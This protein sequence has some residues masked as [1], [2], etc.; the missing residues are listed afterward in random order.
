VRRF[1]LKT[2]KGLL[3]LVLA[4]MI[5]IAAWHE[6]AR[7]V[8]PRLLI[9]VLAAG[10]FDMVVLRLRHTRWQFP[11]GAVL[12]AMIAGMVLSVQTPW[13]VIPAASLAG[14]A[15]KYAFRTRGANVFNPAALGIVA[16]VPAFHP[17]QNWWGAL[18]DVSPL[19][20]LALPA[21]GIFIARRVNKLALV[22]AFLGFYFALFTAAAF[23]RDPA[24]VSEIFRAPDLQA[25]LYFTFFILTDPPTSPIAPRDQ[26]VFGGIVA[27]VSFAI[28]ESTGA[29]YYLLAGVLV[30]NVWEARRRVAWRARRLS[31]RA[32]TVEDPGPKR[33]RDIMSDERRH[34]ETD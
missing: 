8:A 4:A 27:L 1:F 28:F 14:V 15:A 22:V 25:A 17:G 13:Y 3:T 11:S 7:L 30:A 16:L 10:L 31:P 2:P 33:P 20:Q 9:A 21:S 29:V 24:W 26:I 5:A 18:P 34:R 6:G 19:A 23:V 12:T 32:D